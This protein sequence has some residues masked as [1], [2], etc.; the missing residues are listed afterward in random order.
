MKVRIARL[1]TLGLLVF[2]NPA[3]AQNKQGNQP[4]ATQTPAVIAVK[5]HA[6][7]CGSCKAMGNVFEELQAK[8]DG[9]PVLYV[10]LD[11]TREFHRLQSRYL[12]NALGLENIWKEYGNKTGFILL[13]DGKTRAHITT[14]TK[15]HDLKQMGEALLAAVT[16]ASK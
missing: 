8:F 12:A 11:H 16:K 6:D 13:I 4:D 1:I 7:W 5:F 14:L 3:W 2:M 10:V 9:Q 15:E